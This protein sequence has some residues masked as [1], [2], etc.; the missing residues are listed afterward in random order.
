MRNLLRIMILW[1]GIGLIQGCSDERL[2]LLDEQAVIL[3]FGDSLTV[4]MG[5]PAADS[6]PSVL[7]RLSGRH[8]ESA[9]ISGEVSARGLERLPAELSR[10]RPDVLILLHGGNDIL[11]NQSV[12]ELE[13]NLDAMIRLARSR[14]VEVVLLGVPEKKL[15][16]DAAPLYAELAERHDLVFIEDLLSGLLRD[17]AMKSDAVH[18]NAQGYRALAEGIHATLQKEGAL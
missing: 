11:R 4:G 14:G 15:F 17:S 12:T 13:N 18:L 8:V 7:A 16:S 3:A 1:M 9:G 6:Y 5:V 10:V 2:E